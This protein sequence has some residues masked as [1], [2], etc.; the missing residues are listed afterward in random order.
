M[1]DLNN[2]DYFYQ[3]FHV[4]VSSL[5]SQFVRFRASY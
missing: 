5:R 3:K 2:V 4:N 1:V